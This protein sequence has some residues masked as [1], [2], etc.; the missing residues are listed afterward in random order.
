M[1]AL[2]TLGIN[3]PGLIWHLINF[4][5]LLFILQRF[6]FPPVLQLLDERQRRIRE[7]MEQA[8][9]LRVETASAE[10][11]IKAQL[12]DARRQGQEII[13]QATQ[14]ADRIKSE[15]QQQAQ[16]E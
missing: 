13:N 11:R 10:E 14:I 15:R 12:D 16:A 1:Q 6:V 8:E 5:V 2:E 4:L 9:R 3:L 7:S